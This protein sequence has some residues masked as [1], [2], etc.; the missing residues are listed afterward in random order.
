MHFLFVL[1]DRWSVSRTKTAQVAGKRLLTRVSVPV[2]L[3][4]VLE[5]EG[6]VAYFALELLDLV[7]LHLDVF[8]EGGRWGHLFVADAADVCV[9]VLVVEVNRPLRA[10][11]VD[12]QTNS[13]P[14]A[15]VEDV[16][17]SI[18]WPRLGDSY[19]VPRAVF[20]VNAKFWLKSEALQT[21]RTIH[22]SWDTMASI[23]VQVQPNLRWVFVV[24][25]VIALEVLQFHVN[26]FDV[27]LD[28]D[29]EL[30]LVRANITVEFHRVQVLHLQVIFKQVSES[31][32]STTARAQK[33]IAELVESQM[34]LKWHRRLL[35]L[36]ADIAN[37]DIFVIF[38]HMR[39]FGGDQIENCV[40]DEATIVVFF[41]FLVFAFRN[42]FGAGLFRRCLPFLS[43]S[44]RF[45]GWIFFESL[46]NRVIILGF[47]WDQV[48][49]QRI[50]V[51]T[52][53]NLFEWVGGLEE[54][55]LQRVW[56]HQG[57]DT[58]FTYFVRH[59]I[60]RRN[61]KNIKSLLWNPNRK[62]NLPRHKK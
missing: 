16:D 25:A 29:L 14:K 35:P 47:S 39:V 62:S 19:R 26:G 38:L 43:G 53:K 31:E 59:W 6:F 61:L 46:F 24:V 33:S 9:F 4:W 20:L 12:V 22:G 8:E 28:I 41:G 21:V 54:F 45:D 10:S 37:F 7:V 34:V 2:T 23:Q 15:V 30:R 3:Q 52:L 18:L 42:W 56:S 60:S 27:A 40:A 36:I 57:S 17:R 13:A 44:F 51:E 11:F 5:A 48:Y 49:F 1:R 50:C 58:L 55:L 32:A